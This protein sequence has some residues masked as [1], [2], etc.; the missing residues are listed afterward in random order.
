MNR[1]GISDAE[2]RDLARLHGVYTEYFDLQGQQQIATPE[3]LRALLRALGVND[4][5]PDALKA[6]QADQ[7]NRALPTEVICTAQTQKQLPLHTGCRW[8]ILDEQGNLVAEGRATE[9]LT[10]P[11]LP[12]G[13]YRLVTKSGRAQISTRLLVAPGRAPDLSSQSGR[14][15]YWGVTGALYG[16][17]SAT[18]GGLGTY[19]DL[20]TLAEGLGHKGAQFLGINPVHALGWAMEDIISPYSPTHRGFL[21]ID[22]I[23]TQESLGPSPSN[24]LIDYKKFRTHHRATLE[25]EFTQDK[26]NPAFRD[27]LDA[28][29]ADLLSFAQFEAISSQ[30]GP[31][32]HQWPTALHSPGP[33]THKAAGKRAD[34]HAWLQWQ[35][36]M[37]LAM[38]Q[39]KAKASGMALGLYLDLAVGPR[40]DGAEVWMNPET[41][42]QG[43][44]I[45][46]PPDH[47]SPEGQSWALAAHAPGPLARADY[48]PFRAMLRK[49]MAQCGLLRIDHALG[50]A[51]SYWLPDDGSPGGYITQP[52]DSL[53]A[54]IAI[55]A[56]RAGCV[57]IGEDLG[58][59][60]TGFREQMNAAGLYSYA[61][62]Q[63]ETREDGPLLPI[64]H[65]APQALACFGTHDTPTISGFWHGTDIEWWHKVGWLREHDRIARHSDRARQRH[66]LR[67]IYNIPD[68]ADGQTITDAVHRELAHAPSAL[69]SV[70][71]DDAV[72]VTETQNLPGT[73]DEHPNWR[74]RLSID[75]SAIASSDSVAHV[76]D[77]MNAARPP[78][79]GPSQSDRPQKEIAS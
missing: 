32:F 71:L 36:E 74:R 13:Y 48:A 12:V 30:Y 25:A 67:T 22:H 72:G 28:A 43:V 42:A 8:Q 78:L 10:L 57:V 69:V 16:L 73:I 68:T 1:S 62:W 56:H 59:V 53:L 34:F 20:A 52:F 58:L 9:D 46:A 39:T 35:A 15:R 18:N 24:D 63:F 51:R 64:D 76:A 75:V 3:T 77:V 4:A 29:P 45:G 41:I 79:S 26:Y 60:P 2:L 6:A 66:S 61:V 50:L 70:Q 11:P 33:A 49:L 31:D 14:K 7:K 38:A 27:W 47:L 19:A 37:Q 23:A 17:T 5:L 40:P 54:V 21:N 65:L 44:T 55:E